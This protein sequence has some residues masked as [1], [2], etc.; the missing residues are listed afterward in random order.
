MNA[1]ERIKLRRAY[2]Q[3]SDTPSDINEH[4]PTLR[5]YASRCSHVTECG[6]RTCVSTWAF[7]EG[8]AEGETGRHEKRPRL[9]GIDLAWHANVESAMHT[10]KAVGISYE[11][12]CCN[13]IETTIE[14]TDLL[15]IDTWHV[16]GHLKR[17]LAKH[18][19]ATRRWIIL[20]DTTVDGEEGESI[21][22]GYDI[23]DQ[24]EESG[25]PEEEIR[26]GIWPAVEEFLA[27]HPTEWVLEER[28]ANC[29][30]LT[31]LARKTEQQA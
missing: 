7:L 22:M 16:Y 3:A 15:F 2:E 12:R 19:G 14:P 31:V 26:K 29:N 10:A 13:D 17:E 27:E 25:Y 11:F 28:W 18:H 21:R 30:G 8:L 6:V 1:I 23:A 9:V 24:V 4:I 5:E 20:H